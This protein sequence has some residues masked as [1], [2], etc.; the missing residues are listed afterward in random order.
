MLPEWNVFP[1]SNSFTLRSSF[2]FTSVSFIGWKNRRKSIV[3]RCSRFTRS[4]N[5]WS[6]SKEQVSGTYTSSQL[7][8]SSTAP[9]TN[10]TGSHI[11]LPWDMGGPTRAFLWLRRECSDSGQAWVK[12]PPLWPGDSE[13]KSTK[14]S[15]LLSGGQAALQRERNS[16]RPHQKQEILVN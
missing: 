13:T 9:F 1:V 4:S 8:L 10:I 5:W 16:V 12:S 6:Q 2:P 11:V 14:R 7:T 3:V 15:T